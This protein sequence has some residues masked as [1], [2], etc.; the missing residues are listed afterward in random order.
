MRLFLWEGNKKKYLAIVCCLF[1]MSATF[2]LDGAPGVAVYQI[3]LICYWVEYMSPC[4]VTLVDI[5][6]FADN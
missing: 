5:S 1:F 6:V 4:K 2:T 3:I